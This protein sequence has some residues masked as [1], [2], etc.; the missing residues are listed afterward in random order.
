[1]VENHDLPKDPDE[2]CECPNDPGEQRIVGV[3][4]AGF[5]CNN[6]GGYVE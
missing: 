1:M 5:Y 4:K 3:Y 2:P 6:C